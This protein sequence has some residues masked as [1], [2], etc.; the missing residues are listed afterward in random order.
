MCYSNGVL[1]LVAITVQ[2]TFIP[3]KTTQTWRFRPPWAAGWE[4][5]CALP[6]PIRLQDLLNSA[7]PGTEKKIRRTMVHMPPFSPE[8][9]LECYFRCHYYNHSHCMTIFH[10]VQIVWSSSFKC[11]ATRSPQSTRW[12]KFGSRETQQHRSQALS[13]SRSLERESISHRKLEPIPCC[14]FRIA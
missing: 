10:N 11:A 14:E 2:L 12:Q 3:T 13:S 5:S 6:K 4:N 9:N 7:R 8:L 1:I